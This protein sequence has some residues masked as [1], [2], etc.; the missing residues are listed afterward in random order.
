MN[1]EEKAIETLKEVASDDFD[2]LGDDISPKMAQNI[3]NVID[4]QQKEIEEKN[5]AINK[6]SKDISRQLEEIE[7][8]RIIIFAG[9]EKVK[10]LE[11]GNRS[12][13]E[14]RI[15]WKN[16]YYKEKAKNK[17]K[18][19]DLETK[20]SIETID[21]KYNQEERDEET[22]PRYKI[23]EKIKK[24][25]EIK[26]HTPKLVIEYFEELLEENYNE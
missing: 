11:K 21:N 5:I 17:E 10:E 14:S 26:W 19:V 2:T 12:L 13:M 15:K 23:R 9:A 20:L 4:K 7:E 25:K 22:I 8:K 6:M 24:A 18:I 16:R 1:E 3:L